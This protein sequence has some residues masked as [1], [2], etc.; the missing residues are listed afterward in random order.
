MEFIRP[1]T[2]THCPPDDELLR[3]WSL[4]LEDLRFV[5]NSSTLP[6]LRVW[7]GLQLCFLRIHGALARH[8]HEFPPKSVPWM[9]RQ[10]SVGA[11]SDLE[12]PHRPATWAT[13]REYLLTYTGWV[14][15]DP[16]H[17]IFS[18]FIE[19]HVLSGKSRSEISANLPAFLQS[20]KIIPP[21]S[22]AELYRHLGSAIEQ[23]SSRLEKQAFSLL[24]K[25][26]L[27]QIEQILSGN[28]IGYPDFFNELRATPPFP[29]R[30]QFYQ[31]ISLET[32]LFHIKAMPA[33]QSC[34]NRRRR[35]NC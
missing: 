16:N 26:L 3:Y 6:S 32:S 22:Q 29:S 12:P 17:P 18:D 35:K 5:S 8:E 13:Q 25:T 9:N 23:V 19:S 14:D 4:T 7:L 15:F 20:T 10:F 1:I 31:L 2:A 27:D 33:C 30:K 28:F 21:S 11:N 34:G 24:P